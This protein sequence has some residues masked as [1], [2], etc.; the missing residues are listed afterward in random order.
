MELGALAVWDACHP[1]L[2][3]HNML[4]FRLQ[5]YLCILLLLFCVIFST[6][7]SKIALI[8]SPKNRINKNISLH[9]TIKLPKT[10]HIH[11]PNK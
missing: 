7:A 10:I 2:Y 1:A 5:V 11:L 4:Q 6:N 9:P 8:A 3:G